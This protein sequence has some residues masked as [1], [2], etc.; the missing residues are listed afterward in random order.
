MTKMSKT[1]VKTELPSTD[2]ILIIN[3]ILPNPKWITKVFTIFGFPPAFVNSADLS[4]DINTHA[5][6]PPPTKRYPA[7]L[8]TSNK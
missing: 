4:F 6:D 5:A 3:R 2:S 7:K 8:I 1:I